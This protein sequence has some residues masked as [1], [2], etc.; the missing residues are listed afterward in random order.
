MRPSHPVGNLRAMVHT[1]IHTP[2]GTISIFAHGDGDAINAVEWGRAPDGDGSPLLDEARR[3]LK[4]YFAGEL[5]DFD[6]PLDPAG[7]PFQKA[8]CRAMIAIPF[9]QR[10]TYG[11]IA[12]KLGQ[13]AQAVGGACGHNPIPI[14]IPCH[15]VVG[16]DDTMTGFSGGE[17]IETKAWLLRHEGAL[18]A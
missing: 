13:S 4:A 1:S 15:R 14:I 11:D 16:T 7:S 3:Q 12:R 2:V 6:L 17:G 9:G 8:V 18:L 10:R 5:R